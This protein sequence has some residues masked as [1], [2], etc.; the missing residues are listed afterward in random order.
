M[1]VFDADILSLLLSPNANPPDDS[2]GNPVGHS[3]QRLQYLVETLEKAKEKILIPTPALSEF[4]VLVAEAASEYLT[5]LNN[6]AAFKVIDFDQRAAIEAAN[7]T[8]T[9]IQGG[10]KKG[11]SSAPWA[12]IKFD[13]QII[14]IAIVEGAHTIYSNDE[15]IESL[16]GQTNIKVTGVDALPLPPPKTG[17]LPL[18]ESEKDTEEGKAS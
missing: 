18:R 9:A 14:A 12:K 4:L 1:V 6:S 16:G 5:E 11:G 7:I 10:S 15:H 3:Q 17:S 13:R 2:S 8:R